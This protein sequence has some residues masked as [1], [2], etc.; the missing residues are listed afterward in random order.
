MKFSSVVLK[1]DDRKLAASDLLRRDRRL[2]LFNDIGDAGQHGACATIPVL[3]EA[4]KG[5][6]EL[7]VFSA[8]GQIAFVCDPE[9][10]EAMETA[11][12]LEGW[13]DEGGGLPIVLHPTGD[14]RKQA[15]KDRGEMIG[16]FGIR[17][18][19]FHLSSEFRQRLTHQKMVPVCPAAA[20]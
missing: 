12:E 13:S 20:R 9:S 19:R 1:P 4:L 16:L 14:I 3:G 7:G 2:V 11:E 17:R 5:F 8:F 15:V 18:E 10:I 6:L